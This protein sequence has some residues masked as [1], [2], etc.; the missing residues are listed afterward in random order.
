MPTGRTIRRVAKPASAPIAIRNDEAESTKKPQY[1]KKP[2]MPRLTH[3]LSH[4]HR[5]REALFAA[6][7]IRLPETKS[8]TV[9]MTMRLRNRTSHHP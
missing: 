9:E 6:R 8:T 5:R 4:N 3:R 7:C 1:L 2:R